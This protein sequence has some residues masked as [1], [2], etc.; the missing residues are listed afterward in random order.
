MAMSAFTKILL[1]E[2]YMDGAMVRKE[3]TFTAFPYARN[4]RSFA[5]NGEFRL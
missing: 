1:G 5:F 3:N 4:K 2:C